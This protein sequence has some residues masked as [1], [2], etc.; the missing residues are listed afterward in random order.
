[1]AFLSVNFWTIPD[2][3]TSFTGNILY[4]N[5]LNCTYLLLQSLE[6]LRVS[7]LGHKLESVDFERSARVRRRL[8]LN[9]LPHGIE[10]TIQWRDVNVSGE[11]GREKS[12]IS[13]NVASMTHLKFAK[14]IIL[15]HFFFIKK[16]IFWQIL[17]V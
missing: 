16:N 7:V 10:S 1:M 3:I 17:Y 15:L 11:G 2:R 9:P 13:K 4:F 8:I 5:K 14:N 6:F 12:W